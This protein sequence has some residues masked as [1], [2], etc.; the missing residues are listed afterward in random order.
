M[1]AEIEEKQ[2]WAKIRP[3]LTQNYQ[4][5]NFWADAIKLF[6]KRVKRKFFDPIQLII[7]AKTLKGEGFT[8]VTVQCAIIE[9]FSAFRQ[10]KIFNHSKT[11]TSPKYEYKES[12]KMFTSFLRTAKIFE[13]NFWTYNAKEKIVID[14]PYNAADFYKNV[15]CGLMHEARTKDNWHI[16]ATPLTISVKKG[17][18]IIVTQDNKKKIYRTV[19][20]Y[21]LLD[22]LT[23][24]KLDLIKQDKDGEILRKHFARKLDNLFDY[25]ADQNSWWK[26]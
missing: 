19:L 17:G 11:G 1:D 23:E 13:N 2:E 24:Y 18:K 22:Y 21:R 7:N 12:Q 25:K 16:T 5:D 26:E 10:G 15:R 14:K 8:I 6:D 3:N 4:Y 9:M 20:H